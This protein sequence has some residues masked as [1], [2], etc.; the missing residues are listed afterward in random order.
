LVIGDALAA[1]PHIPVGAIPCADNLGRDLWINSPWTALRIAL[2][3]EKNGMCE[4]GRY[5]R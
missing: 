5:P 3:R 2:S 1:K 4:P